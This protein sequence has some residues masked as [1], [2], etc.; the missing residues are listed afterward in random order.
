MAEGLMIK[1]ADVPELVEQRCGWKPSVATVRDWLDAGKILGR[2][3]GGRVFVDSGSVF[4]L[5]EGK[6]GIDQ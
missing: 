3:I 2:K 6:E 1:I 4:E 5:F